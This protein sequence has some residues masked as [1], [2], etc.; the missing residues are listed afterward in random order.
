MNKLFV[1][2]ITCCFSFQVY[3]N[4]PIKRIE[5]F[6]SQ[7]YKRTDIKDLMIEL[8]SDSFKS[9]FKNHKLSNNFNKVNLYWMQ[10]GKL[11]SNFKNKSKKLRKIV[12]NYMEMIKSII[13]SDSLKEYLGDFK[14][15][16]KEKLNGIEALEKNSVK[17]ENSL[18][19]KILSDSKIMVIQRRPTGTF[20]TTY[21]YKKFKWSKNQYLLT[22]IDKISSEGLQI[23][24]FSMTIDYFEKN[25]FVGL[26]RVI[27]TRLSNRILNTLNK[28]EAEREFKE[29]LKI[30]EYKINKSVALDWFTKN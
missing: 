17:K 24:E 4:S 2:L 13:F 12:N 19:I 7:I 23:S 11:S 1:I 27:K 14:L 28:S 20:K 16:Y 3:S 30:T 9:F 15:E 6:E 29:E 10:S 25:E 22:S 26:P 8:K 18:L 5:N 21:N